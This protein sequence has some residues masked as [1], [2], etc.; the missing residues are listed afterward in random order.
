LVQPGLTKPILLEVKSASDYSFKFKFEKGII[1]DGYMLQHQVYMEATG[2]DEGCFIAISKNSGELV[3]VWTKYD[4]D[5]VKWARQNYTL[6]T[7]ASLDN[8]PPRYKD[9]D[10]YGPKFNKQGKMTLAPLCT[11][12]SHRDLCW[13]DL[14]VEVKYGKPVFFIGSLPE[15]YHEDDTEDF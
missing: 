9:G 15:D 12:C 3:E 10:A 5:F 1:D 6:A 7:L 2:L 4:P 11:Y 8:L 13:P 14:E